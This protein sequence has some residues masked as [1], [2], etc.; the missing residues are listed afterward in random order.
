MVEYCIVL[1]P[2]Y[3]VPVLY[4]S[5]RN[6]PW[7][8]SPS[9]VDSAYMLLVPDGMKGLIQDV[10]VMGAISYAVS[11]ALLCFSSHTQSPHD[12]ILVFLR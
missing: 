7:G 4:F 9:S 6:L 2:A 3:G 5:L 1:S 12:R 8:L 11:L 10:G